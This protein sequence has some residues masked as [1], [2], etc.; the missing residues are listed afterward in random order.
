PATFSVSTWISQVHGI[1]AG[2]QR[3]S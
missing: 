3:L 2:P 1:R